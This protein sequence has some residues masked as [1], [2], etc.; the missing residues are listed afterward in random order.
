[1]SAP[2]LQ[3]ADLTVDYGGDPVVAGACL[4][5]PARSAVGL[6]GASGSGKSTLASALVGLLP[7]GGRVRCGR[8]CF[9]GVD[10]LSATPARLR[11][12]RGARLGYV[13]QDA[14]RSLNPTMRSGDQVR[15]ALTVH[16][17]SRR[18]AR[19]RVAE[20]LALVEL[21]P[22]QGRAYPHE[23][24]GGQ[25]QRVAIAAAIANRPALLVADEPTTGLDVVVQE[26]LLALLGDLR[27][28]LGLAL[29]VV[30][31]DRDAL[32]VLCER[33]VAMQAGRLVAAE[34]T[35]TPTES[36]GVSGGPPE[37]RP[38]APPLVALRGVSV[39]Y[40][41]RAAR[42]R[43][44]PA[45]RDVDLAVCRG[46]VL[47]LIG[48]SGAGKSTL[49][50]VVLGLVVPDRGEAS[51]DGRAL[52]ALGGRALRRERARMHLI[53]QDAYDAFPA[54]AGVRRALSEPLAIH[55]ADA[56]ADAELAGALDAAGLHPPEDFLERLVEDLSGGE[57]QRLA[58]ARAFVAEPELIVA[59]EPTSMLDPGLRVE[60]TDRLR[61]AARERGL[62]ILLITHDLLLA[63]RACDRIAV[64]A[65]GRVVEV[66]ATEEVLSSPAASETRALLAAGAAVS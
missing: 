60:L 22:E 38:D 8:A 29:L 54:G 46:E 2:L 45:L 11:A 64:L 42:S 33:V 41:R 47:G 6:V 43:V 14:V 53:F 62:T 17:V 59:D 31:H 7:P 40:R 65:E 49:A 55:G 32:A 28:R 50:Q 37:S 58:L 18:G 57:R 21:S 12:L 3:V 36:I 16:G 52:H 15:E 30:S 23:L 39:H 48:R 24:S 66:G 61:A 26:R 51:F 34:A 25:R 19:A 20:L 44:V 10:L 9:D 63:R 13:T 1:M 27:E 56:P 4:E 5:L 35:E